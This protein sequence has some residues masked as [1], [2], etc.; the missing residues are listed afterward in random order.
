MGVHACAWVAWVWRGSMLWHKLAFQ[1]ARQL[2]SAAKRLPFLNAPAPA[3]TPP[4]CQ[5]NLL[6]VSC[7]GE[8]WQGGMALT[9]VDALDALVL[10]GRRDDL[11]LALDRLERVLH[12][13]IDKE[14]GGGRLCVR[15]RC[16]AVRLSVGVRSWLWSRGLEESGWWLGRGGGGCSVGLLLPT[17]RPS[18]RPP[19][20]VHV[21]E[22]TIRM[23][24]GLLSSHM[25]IE[26][27]PGLAGNYTGGWRLLLEL[28]SSWG[29]GTDSAPVAADSPPTQ[30]PRDP[31][32]TPPHPTRA[33]LPAADG[34]R[35]G[36]QD[37][38]GV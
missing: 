12:F 1:E 11:A 9:L 3:P 25:L 10:L 19:A 37:A 15:A 31:H 33:R 34:H 18:P 16:G 23:L 26:R 32:L 8:D 30:R 21:F 36:R 4:P 20:Q 17:R 14:V 6:P 35:P 24:G 22:V 2:I 29:L 38:A 5:D 27:N 13:D 7:Q 28:V